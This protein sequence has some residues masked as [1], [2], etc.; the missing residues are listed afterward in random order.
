M[1]VMIVIGSVIAATAMLYSTVQVWITAYTLKETPT[2]YSIASTIILIELRIA[3][4]P[5][6]VVDMIIV[7]GAV[8]L[9]VP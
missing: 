1:V 5:V 7:K 3:M 2:V 8:E 4:L 9:I 6:V